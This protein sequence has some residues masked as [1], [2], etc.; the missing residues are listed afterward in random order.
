MWLPVVAA[1][2]WSMAVRG[3]DLS[4]DNEYNVTKALF[5]NEFTLGMD[6]KVFFR[7]IVDQTYFH[8][9]PSSERN[10]VTSHVAALHQEYPNAADYVKHLL[11]N[12][13]ENTFEFRDAASE[14]IAAP[15]WLF[16]ENVT[17]LALE[18]WLDQGHSIIHKPELAHLEETE[19]DALR[20]VLDEIFL[21]GVSMHIYVSGRKTSGL[22]P[23]T[24]P[25][26]VFAKQI[27]GEKVWK[28]CLPTSAVVEKYAANSSQP[29]RTNAEKALLQE[30]LK[31]QPQGMNHDM[32]G[33]P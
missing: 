6:A 25:Y 1:V 33:R 29:I 7:T 14:R 13:P 10:R 20:N 22:Q 3:L 27:Y 17:S 4:T 8:D 11:L 9:W 32:M 30:I 18:A 19:F 2:L 5:E 28:L 16:E 24:D 12:Y 23:H 31:N 21:G 15:T 26:A